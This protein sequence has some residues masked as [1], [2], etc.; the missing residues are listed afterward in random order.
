MD[1]YLCIYFPGGSD[2][3]KIP[4]KIESLSGLGVVKVECGSQFSL[5]L[6]RSGAVYTWG[7]AD[8]HRY[9]FFQ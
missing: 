2:G 4:M 3:C 7:K 8:Y 1:K 5:A 6:T 9:Y